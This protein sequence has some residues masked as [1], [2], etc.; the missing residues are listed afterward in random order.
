VGAWTRDILS[1]PGVARGDSRVATGDLTDFSSNLST[2]RH[3]WR[4]RLDDESIDVVGV[5]AGERVCELPVRDRNGAVLA[6]HLH[7]L[8]SDAGRQG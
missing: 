2:T 5:L 7:C 8:A 4:R 3:S 6:N 1:G